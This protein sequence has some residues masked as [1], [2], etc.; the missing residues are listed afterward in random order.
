M[1]KQAYIVSESF[2]FICCTDD[3][4]A[5]KWL[6]LPSLRIQQRAEHS[7]SSCLHRGRCWTLVPTEDGLISVF[8]V[9]WF[10]GRALLIDSWESP[11]SLGSQNWISDG[12]N[13]VLF[14][15]TERRAKHWS[16][17]MKCHIL[18]LLWTSDNWFF[19]FSSVGQYTLRRLSSANSEW[20]MCPD[21][22]VFHLTVR[23]STRDW[24]D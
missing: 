1:N 11:S 23:N 5:S 19:C 18:V 22:P 7:S 12:P 20:A 21:T 14:Q 16:T 8:L 24:R 2:A 6:T 13:S 9:H 3:L 4:L 15:S 17:S 10:L